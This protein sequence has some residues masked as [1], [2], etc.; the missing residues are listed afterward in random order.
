MDYPN[1][2][3]RFLAPSFCEPQDIYWFVLIVVGFTGMDKEDLCPSQSCT[4]MEESALGSSEFPV[5]G[6]VQA[7]ADD[8]F[9]LLD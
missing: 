4:K 6:G 3:A 5:T 7:K 2:L 9:R 8:T 1:I